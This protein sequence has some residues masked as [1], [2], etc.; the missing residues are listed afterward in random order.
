MPEESNQR[1]QKYTEILTITWDCFALKKGK[2]LSW[3]NI[4][5]STFMKFLKTIGPPG[6]N[7]KQKSG[8]ILNNWT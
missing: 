5:K 3:S 7:K 8:Q 6:V 2:I 1:E 4:I